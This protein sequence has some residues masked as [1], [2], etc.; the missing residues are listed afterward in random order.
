VG[1][2]L[3]ACVPKRFSISEN[4]FFSFLVF[5]L[6]VVVLRTTGGAIQLSSSMCGSSPELVG[7][8]FFLPHP[9]FFPTLHGFLFSKHSGIKFGVA[10][11]MFTGILSPASD[12]TRDAGEGGRR[13]PC[14]V[15]RS[16]PGP[17]QSIKGTTRTAFRLLGKQAFYAQYWKLFQSVSVFTFLLQLKI[18]TI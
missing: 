10:N 6:K 15:L 9:I 12:F 7:A 17:S 5:L 4:L 1:T 13:D 11:S 2:N 18:Q 14:S 16:M 3:F 8:R